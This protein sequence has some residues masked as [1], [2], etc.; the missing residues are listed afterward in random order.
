[1]I[2]F[3]LGLGI[4]HA[5][6]ESV[7]LVLVDRFANG[8]PSND[9]DADLDDPSAFHGGD[10]AGLLANLDHI[11][12]LGFTQVWL[13]PI[14]KM[15]TETIGGHGAF[16]G[17]WTEDGARLEPRFGTDAEW[18][19]LQEAFT[20]RDM[21]LVIDM[22]TNHVGP[23]TPLTRTHPQWFHTRGDITDWSDPVQLVTH[24]VHGL[25]DLNQ[26]LPEVQAH[27]IQEG[28][29][30][31]SAAAA[32]RLDAVRHI[33][34]D[35][36]RTYR[37]AIAADQTRDIPLYGEIFEGNPV[38]LAKQAEEYGLDHT[39]DFPLHYAL[40]DAFCQD[41]DLR[42]LAS[43]LSVDMA[44]PDGH[45]HLTFLDNHDLPRIRTACGGD[46]SKV[47]AAMR[48]LL[49]LRGVPVVTYGT[50]AGLQGKEETQARTDMDFRTEAPVMQVLK[51]GLA[52][53]REI[54]A[55]ASAP[56]RVKTLN[57]EE[58]ILVRPS[59]DRDVEIRI[60][61]SGT[62]SITSGPSTFQPSSGPGTAQVIAP[63][64]HLE[65]GETLWLA[66]SLPAFGGWQ[67]DGAIGPL[68]PGSRTSIQLEPGIVV[69]HKLFIRA[70]S[71]KIRWAPGDNQ[72]TAT[73]LRT[74]PSSSTAPVVSEL[75]WPAP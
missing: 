38:V 25:P 66:G 13:T 17:Y 31:W 40:V 41:G 6:P 27:L 68:H 62:V 36:V 57:K 34:P 1:V 72:Y 9:A 12:G 69:A 19:R 37:D 35:F 14:A 60:L 74:P 3:L 75:K 67:T 53:R 71:G 28:R 59:D 15:R 58:L 2:A 56:T 44:Y 48:V 32:L 46:E 47:A 50:E 73:G 49:V 45:T 21:G 7:Y 52:Q 5:A 8:D 26:D 42:T 54:P 61:A 30:W 65:E 33:S 51:E 4:A 43:V 22:V 11:Q 10:L 20:E 39:F 18:L 55:L 24:D 16:H 63:S 29:E 23:D 64:M 70:A